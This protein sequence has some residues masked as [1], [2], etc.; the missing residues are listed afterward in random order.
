MRD[1]F[2]RMLTD[3]EKNLLHLM[4]E[5]TES[6]YRAKIILL[7]DEGYIVPQIRKLTNHHDN[8]I[9]KWIHRF[10]EKGIDGIISKKHNHKQHKFD[11]NIE[12]K[13]VNIS[14]SNPRDD[15]GLG[16][17]TWSLRVLAGFLMYDL[18][19]V[20]KIS[21]SEIRNILLKHKIKWR[22]SKTVLSNKRS[23]NYPAE[24]TLKKST[25]NSK[26]TTHHQILCYCI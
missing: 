1:T 20:D 6:G 2:L 10:N 15:F 24:Y 12:E 16:F 7:K 17:S 3:V 4:L 9:R 14:S 23:N 26:G 22:K 25:L 13:I 21:H 5:D 18:K 19:L 8:N 11:N